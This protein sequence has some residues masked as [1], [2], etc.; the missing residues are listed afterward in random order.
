MGEELLGLVGE[1][2]TE[3]DEFETD[4]RIETR[5]VGFIREDVFG[6]LGECA[7]P[8]HPFSP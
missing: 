6:N 5:N 8:C 4:A 2:D 3:R 7:R 1:D